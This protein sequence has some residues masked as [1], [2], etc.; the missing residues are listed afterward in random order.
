V[1]VVVLGIVLGGAITAG[2]EALVP[3]PG[4]T[5]GSAAPAASTDTAITIPAVLPLPRD[6]GD[7]AAVTADSIT[8]SREL[9]RSRF[10]DGA[11]GA[12]T[13][14]ASGSQSA[15]VAFGSSRREGLVG[16]AANVGGSSF[17]ASD[18]RAFSSVSSITRADAKRSSRS[19]TRAPLTTASISRGIDD[20]PLLT[21]G[22]VSVRIFDKTAI[23]VDAAC[24]G[25]PANI[26]KSIAPTDHT[27]TRASAS[28]SPRA[29]SGAM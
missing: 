7:P 3:K 19:M 24:A 23:A 10:E 1:L 6:V 21:G 9:L 11:S 28:T 25:L 4:T 12:V 5:N 8:G 16:T 27:S 17:H 15:A 29:C 18:A 20:R 26:S 2:T 22:A 14:S 13:F